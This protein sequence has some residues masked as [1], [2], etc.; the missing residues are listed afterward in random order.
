MYLIFVK[1]RRLIK[2]L[3]AELEWREKVKQAIVEWKI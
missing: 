3:G 2:A 1:I